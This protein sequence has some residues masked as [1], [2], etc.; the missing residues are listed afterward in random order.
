LE[1]GGDDSGEV[2]M[3]YWYDSEFI[4]TGSLIDLISIGIVCEDGRE[5]Y[6]QSAEFDAEKASPWVRENVF[7]HLKKCAT[8]WPVDGAHHVVGQCRRSDCVWR[9]HAQIALEV[10]VF[11]DA[12]Q[13]GKPE[14]WGWCCSYDHVALCQLFG[15]M[16]DVPQGWPH[17][18]CDIQCILDAK[19]I[20]DDMLPRQE[21]HAHHALA[22]ARQIKKIWEAVCQ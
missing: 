20:T 14:L 3:R 17:H 4:D 11:I 5:L 10:A 13:L 21:G 12:E 7:P 8:N 19:G 22:D 15:T 6:L 2:R 9:R 1:S 16:M 18:M